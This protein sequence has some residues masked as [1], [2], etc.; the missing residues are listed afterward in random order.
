MNILDLPPEILDYTFSFID[1]GSFKNVTLACKA[2]N[3][4]A[5]SSGLVDKMKIV[6]DF[7]EYGLYESR[8]DSDLQ[9][10]KY[11]ANSKALQNSERV[12]KSITIRNMRVYHLYNGY[13]LQDLTDLLKLKGNDV[14]NFEINDCIIYSYDYN[15][16]FSAIKNIKHV[17]ITCSYIHVILVCRLPE[18]EVHPPLELKHVET[19]HI[20]N[21]DYHLLDMFSSSKKVRKFSLKLLVQTHQ[22]PL[23]RNFFMH[24]ENMEEVELSN[25]V[26]CEIFDRS[27]GE[28]IKN[29]IT[30]LELDIVDIVNKEDFVVFLQK[31]TKI[32]FIRFR[33]GPAI[34]EYNFPGSYDSVLQAMLR[35]PN[36]KDFDLSLEFYQ[37]INLTIFKHTVNS[38]M[39]NF[40]FFYK[41]K[42][43]SDS[44]IDLFAAIPNTEKIDIT[45]QKS[46][47]A[48]VLG[49][50]NVFA[51]IG[52][53][54]K[55]VTLKIDT[56]AQ[57]LTDL[58]IES[59]VFEHLIMNETTG[60]I[61]SI[62]YEVLFRN[63][64]KRIKILTIG[65]TRSFYSIDDH[66]CNSIVYYLT[67][68]KSLYLLSHCESLTK[69]R[70]DI[71][72]KGCKKLGYIEMGYKRLN[73]HIGILLYNGCYQ[74]TSRFRYIRNNMIAE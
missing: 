48:P 19:L 53:L 54:N 28:T 7:P 41:E 60:E 70:L 49:A 44:I 4:Y 72:L 71:L 62:F 57:Y 61:K 30:R 33:I 66:L 63:N 58:I 2:F 16:I 47:V 11:A 29:N 8:L 59:K 74:F 38:S 10:Y 64:Q 67:S 25:V 14:E 22:Q 37:I 73:H 51:K 31:Q 65:Q 56:D 36:L 12:Y 35:M 21:S 17:K 20:Y 55:L 5:K 23:L 40:T 50:N 52:L 34:S 69:Y 39:K 46:S 13:L 43:D 26:N 6:I 18:N 32:E 9:R 15:A 45:Y 3:E 68:L 27:V 1:A 24:Q 42:Y